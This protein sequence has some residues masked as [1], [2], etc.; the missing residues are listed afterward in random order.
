M[1]KIFEGRISPGSN[2]SANFLVFL[3]KIYFLREFFFVDTSL[4]QVFPSS[5]CEC[6]RFYYFLLSML[7]L[8]HYIKK[9][10]YKRFFK[11]L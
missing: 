11:T 5:T 8:F 6:E 10:S 3:Q 4:C 7:L 1:E 2:L 9:T